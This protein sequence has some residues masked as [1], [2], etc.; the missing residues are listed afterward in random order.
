M[1]RL[2]WVEHHG[3]SLYLSETEL[4]LRQKEEPVFLRYVRQFGTLN[5]KDRECYGSGSLQDDHMSIITIRIA[6]D[7]DPGTHELGFLMG[8]PSIL[9]IATCTICAKVGI[10]VTKSGQSPPSTGLLRSSPDCQASWIGHDGASVELRTTS[11][12]HDEGPSYTKLFA[13]LDI[14]R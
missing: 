10:S 13:K 8:R 5:L 9:S 1:T 7:W 2:V 3:G 14:E 12:D 11:H 4:Y 6:G